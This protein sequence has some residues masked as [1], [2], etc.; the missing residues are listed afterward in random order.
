MLNTNLQNNKTVVN[1]SFQECL[2][3][4]RKAGS[5]QPIVE[6]RSEDEIIANHDGSPVNEPNETTP[7]TE[8]EYVFCS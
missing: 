8:P 6:M 2:I 1:T 3:S 5:K 7:L 4:C